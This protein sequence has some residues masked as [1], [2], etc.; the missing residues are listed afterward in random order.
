MIH[1][2]QPNYKKATLF[3]NIQPEIALIVC[4]PY[5]LSGTLKGMRLPGA[6]SN[7]PAGNTEHGRIRL[8]AITDLHSW[9]LPFDYDR[10]CPNV[11][12]GLASL[13]DI[14]ADARS[15][16]E[17]SFLFDNGDTYQGN[18]LAE[19]VANSALGLTP[20]PVARAL[21]DLGLDAAVPGNHDF[22]FGVDRLTSIVAS[23]PFPFILTNL[24]TELAEDPIADTS[25]LRPFA[26][27]EKE[28]RTGPDRVRTIRLGVLG[29]IPPR[30]PLAANC[31]PVARL[32][33]RD[34]TETARAWIPELRRQGADL[35]V[36]LCHC[37]LGS[38]ASDA[39]GDDHARKVARLDGIDAVVSG[40]RH[41]EAAEAGSEGV[42]PIVAPGA[43]GSHLGLID[44]DLTFSEETG[45]KI[46]HKHCELR[47]ATREPGPAARTVSS[48]AAPLHD[49]VRSILSERIGETSLTLETCL[50]GIRPL[51]ATQLIADAMQREARKRL[52]ERWRDTPL[53]ASAAPY[54]TSHDG[55]PDNFVQ[56]PP[57]PLLLRHAY[58]LYPFANRLTILKMTGSELRDWLERAARSYRP[59]PA[60]TE[61]TEI[62]D[63]S[64]PGYGFDLAHG[65]RFAI[66]LSA[67]P[68]RRIRE[69]ALPCG[70]PIGPH[71]EL[72]LAA[73]SY[74][75]RI[76]ADLAD[77]RIIYES[78]GLIR[79]MLIHHIQT[80]GPVRPAPEPGWHFL[81]QPGRTALFSLPGRAR[82]V[83]EAAGLQ[84]EECPGEDRGRVRIA[85]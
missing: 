50:A 54:R 4:R 57:G 62:L 67:A 38:D 60:E 42:A 8:M 35:V 21:G 26:L 74:R 64:V 36:A 5:R 14:V 46:V 56:I 71:D 30:M 10:D 39:S 48:L 47:P 76:W 65:M 29:F 49:R 16:A 3:K 61:D 9:L 58:L 69:M 40:H 77:D 41:Q 55:S 82:A 37:G 78:P 59:M 79:D 43:F 52:G 33:G 51:A 23:A 44:L 84:W 11:G 66:D 1:R 68:G 28:V 34:I 7:M 27:F 13:A 12:L 85:L 22:D 32:K 15:E 63:P 45:W 2:I 18:V 80:S 6:T 72:L 53:F 73:S 19:H 70:Q 81:P 20:H 83:A 24:V 17:T 25:F 31:R 75:A